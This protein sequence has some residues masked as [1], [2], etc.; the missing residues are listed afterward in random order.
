MAPTTRCCLYRPDPRGLID[1][2]VLLTDRAI[3]F[4]AS[5]AVVLAVGRVGLPPIVGLL[6]AGVLVGP[7]GLGVV[8]DVHQVEVLAEL[9]VALLLFTIGLEF[10]LEKLLRIGRYVAVGGGLQVLLTVTGG[11]VAALAMQVPWTSGVFWGYLAA[12]SSTAIVLRAL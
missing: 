1:L 8:S 3:V 10:S 11:V 4:L 9:D 5:V 12:L 7:H 2:H 6:V